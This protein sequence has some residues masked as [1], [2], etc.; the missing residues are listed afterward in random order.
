MYESENN[1]PNF[2]PTTMETV[3]FISWMEKQFLEDQIEAN[4][5]FLQQFAAD[6]ADDDDPEDEGRER[7]LKTAERIARRSEAQGQI[8]ASHVL[9]LLEKG[10]TEGR[11]RVGNIPFVNKYRVDIDPLSVTLATNAAL[12]ERDPG[13][14]VNQYLDDGTDFNSKTRRNVIVT[15]LNG[16]V[17][18]TSTH[19]K[20][21]RDRSTE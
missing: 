12:K 17:I 16:E 3:S 18:P 1:K 15:H 11:A 9:A 21:T 4:K 2:N 14:I 19:Y 20:R 13:T 6:I 8:L 7:N 10:K 5:L